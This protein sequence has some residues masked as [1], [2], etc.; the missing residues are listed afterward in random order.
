M[1]IECKFRI[2]FNYIILERCIEIER[3]NK[4]LL[5]RMTSIIAGPSSF[6]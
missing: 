3:N 1:L 5:E 6:R 2:I 4:I